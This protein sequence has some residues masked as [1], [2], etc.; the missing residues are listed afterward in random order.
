MAKG[1]CVKKLAER[2][3]MS[4]VEAAALFDEVHDLTRD[5]MRETGEYPNPWDLDAEFVRRADPRKRQKLALEAK[6][7]IERRERRRIASELM[8]QDAAVNAEAHILEFLLDAQYLGAMREG[9]GWYKEL[10]KT[11]PVRAMK[12]F[13]FGDGSGLPGSRHSLSRLR[14]GY[15]RMDFGLLVEFFDENPGVRKMLN[16]GQRD[17]VRGFFIKTLDHMMKEEF[18]IGTT[19]SKFA[20]TLALMAEQSTNRFVEAGAFIK[21]RKGYTP[22]LPSSTKIAQSS[23]ED[24]IADTLRANIIDWEGSYPDKD[25]GMAARGDAA[26][27][28]TIRAR[29]E[30][31]GEM[32]DIYSGRVER[33]E[34][35]NAK[36]GDSIARKF[37][38]GLQLRF[39]DGE[40]WMKFHEMWGRSADPLGL[41]T[42]KI[43][44]QNR[45][46]S[47]MAGFGPQ[48]EKGAYLLRQ[49]LISRIE[50]GEIPLAASIKDKVLAQLRAFDPRDGARAT[51]DLEVHSLR[52]AKDTISTILNP[53]DGGLSMAFSEIV[54]DTL[55]SVNGHAAKWAARVRVAKNMAV[56]GRSVITAMTDVPN[57]LFANVARGRTWGEA[58]RAMIDGYKTMRNFSNA[59]WKEL[60]PYI[61]MFSDGVIG[62]Y[63]S[64]FTLDEHGV[65]SRMQNLYFKVNFLTQWTDAMRQMSATTNMSWLGDN[66]ARGFEELTPRLRD[67]L[68]AHGFTPEKWDAIREATWTAPDGR[69]YVVPG[70]IDELSNDQMR[71]IV[72]NAPVPEEAPW[73]IKR[74]YEEKRSRFM[75]DPE[76][77]RRQLKADLI[78]MLND[79]V[80]YGVIESDDRVRYYSLRGSKPGTLTGEIMRF[81]TQYKSY[82]IGLADRTWSR[83]AFQGQGS[84]HALLPDRMNFDMNIAKWIA[85][86]IT[87]GY[88]TQALSD[89]SKGY[90]PR[91]VFGEHAWDTF[92]GAAIKSGAMAVYGDV[93]FDMFN[94]Y[95]KT[96]LHKGVGMALGPTGDTAM[97]AAEVLW[98]G[99]KSGDKGFAKAFKFAMNNCPYNNIFYGRLALDYAVL[100][101]LED[102]MNP[103][104]VQ[105]RQNWNQRE[106]GR[107]PMF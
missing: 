37:E 73:P 104:A 46:A 102:M 31:L 79:E 105:S 1:D 28:N 42:G 47:V 23:R 97:D 27:P 44:E 15:D 65:M 32:W 88:L 20:K 21:R 103:G 3:G 93:L 95:D 82:A 89:V 60:R 8:T 83:A 100:Y 70:K 7:R 40:A 43:N 13:M 35:G 107:R 51:D 11:D 80:R 2:Y 81:M 41:I 69:V 29:E 49:R 5:I 52:D 99:L 106:L 87:T 34:S 55:Y 26:N 10:G 84:G 17:Q 75:Q 48:P 66:A 22:Y 58:T 9:K 68:R 72:E 53:S 64:R 57:I 38:K 90:Y 94:G 101:N 91:P 92:T 50:K 56:L 25:L 86:S 30:L 71:F 98:A 18:D 36:H 12:A 16:Y 54:G 59:E 39:I 45:M 14:E 61:R 19:E 74:V 33:A 24:F 4:E 67:T 85:L 78:G 96:W 63:H 76:L 77:Y 62:Q 6:T